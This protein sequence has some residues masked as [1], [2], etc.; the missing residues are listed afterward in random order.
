MIPWLWNPF[1]LLVLLQSSRSNCSCLPYRSIVKTTVLLSSYPYALYRPGQNDSTSQIL[2]TTGI[3]LLF[4][5]LTSATMQIMELFLP[6]H[7]C[8]LGSFE[9]LFI[10]TVTSLSNCLGNSCPVYLHAFLGGGGGEGKVKLNEVY[11]SWFQLLWNARPFP[12]LPS[13]S[14]AVFQEGLVGLFFST[15]HSPPPVFWPTRSCDNKPSIVLA[16]PLLRGSQQGEDSMNS[17]SHPFPC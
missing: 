10:L 5:N 3:S 16:W 14:S 11:P 6:S 17:S 12:F 9:I 7:P 8:I 2:W 1:L 13:P 4:K 15:L